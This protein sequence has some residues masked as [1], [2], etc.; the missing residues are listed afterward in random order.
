MIGLGDDP[1]TADVVDLF[2]RESD[3]HRGALLLLFCDSDHRLMTPVFIDHVPQR[4]SDREKNE[5]FEFLEHF[6]GEGSLSLVAGVCRRRGTPL[7]AESG[8][9]LSAAERGCRRAGI[10]LLGC[11]LATPGEISPILP[12]AA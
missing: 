10:Q 4:S 9:W 2:A 8:A 6:G 12:R 7:D 5:L 3:R 1:L 11:Y